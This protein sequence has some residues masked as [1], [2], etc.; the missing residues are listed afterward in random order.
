MMIATKAQN[1]HVIF[2]KKNSSLHKN[3]KIWQIL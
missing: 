3:D 1:L 2:F